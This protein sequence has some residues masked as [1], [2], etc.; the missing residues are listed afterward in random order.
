[1]SRHSVSELAVPWLFLSDAE[2][3]LSL[4]DTAITNKSVAI[5]FDPADADTVPPTIRPPDRFHGFERFEN[6]SV[7][8]QECRSD[9]VSEARPAG[10]RNYGGAVVGG[11]YASGFSAR[12]IERIVG[13]E[14]DFGLHLPEWRIGL[15][16][17]IGEIAEAKNS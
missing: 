17:I 8:R 16:E 6:V 5:I 3:H 2:R 11:L 7:P 9:W 4:I 15:R 1:M 12:D 10:G 13:L 14:R